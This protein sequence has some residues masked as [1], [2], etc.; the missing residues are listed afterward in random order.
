MC[1]IAVYTSTDKFKLNLIMQ[2]L[3][4]VGRL[5]LVSRTR[6]CDVMKITGFEGEC[7][8][9]TSAMHSLSLKTIRIDLIELR[10]LALCLQ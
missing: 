8:D 5:L 4:S 1:T 7:E 9:V 3:Y 6:M 10:E 2:F